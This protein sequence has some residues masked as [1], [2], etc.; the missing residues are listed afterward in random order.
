MCSELFS[1]DAHKHCF[2]RTQMEAAMLGRDVYANSAS[3]LRTLFE[4]NLYRN[5]FLPSSL[6]LY[7][8]LMSG[9]CR[10]AG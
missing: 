4:Q 8:Q 2:K 5:Y 10:S 9:W 6:N 3:S 7:E 1:E